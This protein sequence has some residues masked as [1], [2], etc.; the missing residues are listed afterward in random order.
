MAYLPSS[1]AGLFRLFRGK[2]IIRNIQIVIL[3]LIMAMLS[4]PVPSH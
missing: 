4:Q 1:C 3:M 2:T